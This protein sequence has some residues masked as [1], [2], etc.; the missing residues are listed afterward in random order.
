MEQG[1][2]RAQMGLKLGGWVRAGALGRI[3]NISPEAQVWEFC[4]SPN[5][6]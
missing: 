4:S 3:D 1:G 5:S 2:A 6:S